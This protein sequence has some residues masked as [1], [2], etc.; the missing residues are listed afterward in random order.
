MFD[1]NFQTMLTFIQ[2]KT[3][4]LKW[5]EDRTLWNFLKKDVPLSQH[6]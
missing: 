1:T 3:K 2:N 5:A 4:N 6:T